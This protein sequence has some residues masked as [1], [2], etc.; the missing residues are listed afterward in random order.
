[1]L[2][3]FF[4]LSIPVTVSIRHIGLPYQPFPSYDPLVRR[5]DVRDSLDRSGEIIGIE[6]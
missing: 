3:S 2:S 5:R 4:I 6:T 1:M